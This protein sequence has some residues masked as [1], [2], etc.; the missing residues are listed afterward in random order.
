[1]DL[2][3]M[4]IAI[5]GIITIGVMLYKIA[6]MVCIINII[7]YVIFMERFSTKKYTLIY[8]L[9]P[10]LIYTTISILMSKYNFENYYIIGVI[11]YV[12]SII[13]I[14]STIKIVSAIKSKK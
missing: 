3:N 8:V 12:V 14:I 11:S 4:N 7:L 5:A 6:R 1:M 13:Q 10:I 2:S 9:A